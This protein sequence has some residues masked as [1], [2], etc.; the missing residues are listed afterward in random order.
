MSVAVDERSV[1]GTAPAPEEGIT[2]NPR[3]WM[4]WLSTIF[5]SM[6]A[7]PASVVLVWLIWGTDI[8][9]YFADLRLAHASLIEANQSLVEVR[10]AQGLWYDASAAKFKAETD[11]ITGTTAP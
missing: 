2:I 7:I 8:S 10:K 6:G 11:K 1:A 9:N 4:R 5:G 3:A